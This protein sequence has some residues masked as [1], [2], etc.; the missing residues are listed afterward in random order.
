MKKIHL[1]Q[2]A[3][4]CIALLVAAMHAPLAE[5]SP[6]VAPALNYVTGCTGEYFNNTTLSGSP[7]LVRSDAAIN[8]YWPEYTSP[9]AGVN[10]SYY[11]VRWTCSVNVTTAGTYTFTMR[12]DDGM[13]LL[14]DGNLLIWAWYDQGPSSYSNPIYL[15]AGWHTI[16]VEY[17]NNTLGGTAQVYSNLTGTPTYYTSTYSYTGG[18]LSNCTGEYFNN[19]TLSGSPIL[20]RSDAAINFYWAAGASPGSGVNTGYYSVRWTCTFYAPASSGYTF[21]ILTDDGMN[22]WVDGNYMINAWRDQT[23]SAYSNSIYLG[24][25]AHTVRVEYYNKTMNGTAQIMA[26]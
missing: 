9:G 17:Y 26:R 14:V 11:S 5:A 4:G 25:G 7:V 3:G 6:A 20:T 13:N 8:F 19:A 24:A 12:A 23:P 1:F 22:V 21:S 16:R 15:G 2:I 18:Y 10:T